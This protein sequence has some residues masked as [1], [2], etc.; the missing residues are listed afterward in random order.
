MIDG[1]AYVGYKGAAQICGVINSTVWKWVNTDRI[2]ADPDLIIEGH[3][4]WLKTTVQAWKRK[5]LKTRTIVSVK[6]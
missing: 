1:D 5:N 6:R 2:F 3:G 4:Y